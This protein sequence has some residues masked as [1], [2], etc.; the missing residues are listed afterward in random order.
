MK[1][2]SQAREDFRGLF[3]LAG[4][5]SEQAG[6]SPTT[7]SSGR[8]DL[9]VYF[10]SLARPLTVLTT[11]L[12]SSP[13]SGTRVSARLCRSDWRGRAL[14]ATISCSLTWWSSVSTR[15]REGRCHLGES[16]CVISF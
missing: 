1:R 13:L 7:E 5:G 8:A 4:K 3:Y 11:A 16:G 9:V 15:D 2:V 10:H 14:P 6:G 12:S